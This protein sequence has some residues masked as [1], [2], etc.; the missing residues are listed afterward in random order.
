M[1]PRWVVRRQSRPVGGASL[2]CFPHAGG[3]PGE[4]VRWSDELPEMQ[5]WGVHLPGRT[6]R[7][8]EA[9]FTQMEPLV[10]AFVSATSFDPPFVFFGH[11]LGALTAFEVTR[12]LRRRGRRQP[13]GLILS[14]CPAPPLPATRSALSGVP[15]AVL[16]DEIARRWGE[17]M[18]YLRGDTALRAST[19]ACYRA[20]LAVLENYRYRREPPLECPIVI[21]RGTAEPSVASPEQWA[22]HTRG[23]VH[24]QLV[25]GG[26]FHFRQERRAVLRLLR[27][28]VLG[29]G[30]DAEWTA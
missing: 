26:H 19:L 10:D 8:A 16:L 24:R 3:S 12:E 11:S 28:F 1:T 21:L 18:D 2:Y 15:D 9:P 4:F 5:V 30:G 14:S 7:T 17:S 29:T 20:D 6:T 23:P 25:A 22:Q 13:N 27:E